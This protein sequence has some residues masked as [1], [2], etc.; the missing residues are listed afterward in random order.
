M[1]RAE[2]GVVE[3]GEKLRDDVGAR[4]GAGEAVAQFRRRAAQQPLILGVRHPVDAPLEVLAAGLCEQLGQEPPVLEGD[5]LPARRGEHRLQAGRRD[6]RHDTVER[7]AVEVDDPDDLA[8]VGH[9]RVEHRLPHRALVE[10]GIADQAVL[11]AAAARRRRRCRR[12]T[13]GRSHPRSAPSR[14][15][16]PNR[17]SSRRCRGPSSGSGSS[18]GRGRRAGCRAGRGELASR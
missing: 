18:A 11:A 10:L 4:A 3:G 16:R 9:G 8:E 12:H 7:L 13:G 2:V 1:T 14:R 5:D 6:V 15:C 17:W